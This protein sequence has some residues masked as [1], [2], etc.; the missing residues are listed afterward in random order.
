MYPSM[1]MMKT[2][3]KA[4][5]SDA[6]DQLSDSSRPKKTRFRPVPVVRTC[7]AIVLHPSPAAPLGARP[8]SIT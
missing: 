2:N 5:L 4:A 8:T 3:Q 1:R 6:H 7:A